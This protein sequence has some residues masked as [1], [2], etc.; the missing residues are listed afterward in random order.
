MEG[1]SALTSLKA[2][3]TKLDSTDK[4]KHHQIKLIKMFSVIGAN[5]LRTGL[6]GLLM[7]SACSISQGILD[8]FQVLLVRISF[9]DHMQNAHQ[10]Q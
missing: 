10:L 3:L 1:M 9:P 8:M 2:A 5:T 7:K 6:L 4:P